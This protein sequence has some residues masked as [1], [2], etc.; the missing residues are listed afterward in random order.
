MNTKKVAKKIC[1]EVLK[2][3]GHEFYE[4]SDDY[5]VNTIEKR[6][7][8]EIK[9]DKNKKRKKEKKLKFKL[10]SDSLNREPVNSAI[11]ENACTIEYVLSKLREVIGAI[12]TVEDREDF[13]LSITHQGSDG[14]YEMFYFTGELSYDGFQR[15]FDYLNPAVQCIDPEAY[16]DM[17]DSGRAVCVIAKERFIDPVCVIQNQEDA[18]EM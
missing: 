17:E 10:E 7:K 4:D 9:H 14:E 12:Y 3:L 1:K 6:L 13:G 16:F 5:L 8:K 15:A 18:L 2:E 11:N